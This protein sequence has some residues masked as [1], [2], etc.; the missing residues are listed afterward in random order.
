LP[1]T[2]SN[3]AY[4]A[5]VSYAGFCNGG[6]VTITSNSYTLTVSSAPSIS[7][8]PTA[9]NTY[10]TNA[11]PT[12]SV[13]ASGSGLTYQWY[14]SGGSAVP[15][16]SNGSTYTVAS[17]ETGSTKT[18]VVVVTSSGGCNTTSNNAVVAWFGTPDWG[19]DPKAISTT[20]DLQNPINT[21]LTLTEGSPI[22]F[23]AAVP[24]VV[25]AYQWQSSNDGGSTWSDISTQ[26]GS[27]TGSQTNGTTVSYAHT[28]VNTDYA[29]TYRVNFTYSCGT[30]QSNTALILVSPTTT[31]A[32]SA[33]PSFS[34]LNVNGVKPIQTTWDFTSRGLSGGVVTI[35]YAGTT[36]TSTTAFT[37]LT[38]LVTN[39]SSY[40]FSGTFYSSVFFP[41][42]KGAEVFLANL[43]G[44][45]GGTSAFGAVEKINT[46]A[47]Y[48]VGA[49]NY[50]Q[51]TIASG[52]YAGY[53]RNYSTLYN[54]GYAFRN[55]K[56]GIDEDPLINQ[57]QTE[58]N[59]YVSP[60]NP[61]PAKDNFTMKLNLKQSENVTISLYNASASQLVLEP[62]TNRRFA[63][64]TTEINI[65][66]SNLAAGDYIV[67]IGC[68]C[69][70]SGSEIDYFT[71][72]Q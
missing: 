37:S 47:R 68:R 18:Y 24:T 70:S 1:P 12:L 45:S 63:I 3:G 13:T 10:C 50:N 20:N 31:S 25:T 46:N 43:S 57:P 67:V 28:F 27:E 35:R 51:K 40:V 59:L 42:T 66:F 38:A 36:N 30:V 33:A 49:F 8:Q 54:V 29:T 39:I 21:P 7:S 2:V 15:A 26:G 56:E 55:T 11:P 9:S 64:G 48:L 44:S 62:F 53:Y 41:T 22:T 17:S 14:Y 65:P 5:T 60:I 72:K 6:S 61:N 52:T 16:T 34:T 4:S 19:S 71:I 32:F 58:F 23:Y 69:R